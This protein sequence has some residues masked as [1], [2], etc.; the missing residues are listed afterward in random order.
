MGDNPIIGQ[1]ILQIFLI[2]LNAVFA[3]AEIAV[4]SMNENKLE[5]LA[6]KGDKR[7]IRLRKLTTKPARFLATIQ[8]AITLSGFLG[9]AFAADNFSALFVD[10][11]ERIN[12]PVSETVLD[13]ISVILI[14][15][16]LSYI[17]LVFGELVPKRLAMKK[18]EKLALLLADIIS[19]VAIIAAPV[20][21]LLTQSTNGILR[22]LGIDPEE[23]ENEVSEEEIRMMVEIGNKKGVIE[24]EEKE[25]I[26]NVFEFNDTPIGEFATHRTDMTLLWKNETIEQWEKT[27]Q[28]SR[29]SMYPVCGAT[30]DQIIGILN[31][32]DYYRMKDKT[33]ENMLKHALKPAFF[34]PETIH[35]DVLFKLM[36]RKKNH[37]AVALDEYGGV[38]GIVTMNDILE[39]I[40]G[41]LDEI[42]DRLDTDRIVRIDDTTFRIN[43]TTS[44][45]IV[46]QELKV[47]LPV[48]EYDTF[49]GFVFGTYG[50]VPE[51]G[52][53]FELEV[54]SL[55]IEVKNIRDHR[56]ES[57]IVHCTTAS[58]IKEL[59]TA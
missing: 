31:A 56:L 9:S 58:T 41:N 44:L 19:A 21:S 45:L 36:K 14:T 10:L 18:A 42:E 39:Q 13:T 29:H 46:Q 1:I 54:A 2:G 38:I 43:G 40:V 22:L 23:E 17:T 37:F 57:A 35:A 30:V 24:Q 34:V 32:K 12:L 48:E 5:T 11:L 6:G 33:K 15:L 16:M 53:H 8:V 3:A 28:E 47:S 20:V 26:Q 52:S 59:N 27:I 7:A 4:I 50:F 51:D 49:G 55:R 25:M